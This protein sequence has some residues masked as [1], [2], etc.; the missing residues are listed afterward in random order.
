MPL[1]IGS[2]WNYRVLRYPDGALGVHEV[3]YTDGKPT[4]CTEDPIGAVQPVADREQT[5]V[6]PHLERLLAGD[7]VLQK[8]RPRLQLVDSHHSPFAFAGCAIAS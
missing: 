5:V 2:G 1:K 6:L 8:P 3:F 4:S 7:D